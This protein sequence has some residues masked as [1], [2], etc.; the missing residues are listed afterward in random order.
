[1]QD[2][3]AE[4]ILALIKLKPNFSGVGEAGYP[5]MTKFL[6]FPEGF[7]YLS[8]IGWVDS[9]LF[10]WKSTGN[11]AYV[12]ALENALVLALND[13]TPPPRWGGHLHKSA[14][15]DDYFKYVLHP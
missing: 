14:E 5:L 1:M 15:D 8:S 9:Q 7:D 13:N 4:N 6:A 10:E 11:A 2:D 12:E 3:P